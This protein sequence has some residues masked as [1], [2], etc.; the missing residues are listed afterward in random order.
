MKKMGEISLAFDANGGR[1]FA[2]IV[3]LLFDC[4]QNV[5]EQPL[6]F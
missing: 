4:L 6:N 3:P 5:I 1:P 2:D